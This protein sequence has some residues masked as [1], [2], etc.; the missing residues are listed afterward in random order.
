MKA[1][2]RILQDVQRALKLKHRREA[3]R[4]SGQLDGPVPALGTGSLTMNR[5]S[6]PLRS[7][8][9][10]MSTSP[11]PVPTTTTDVT[12]PSSSSAPLAPSSTTT[13][14]APTA[15]AISTLTAPSTADIDFSPSTG[16]SVVRVR[17]DPHRRLH[18]IP[19]S[20]DGGETLDWSGSG[21]VNGYGSEDEKSE[22]AE[23][24]EKR[25]SLSVSRRGK[26]KEKDKERELLPSAEDLKRLEGLYPSFLG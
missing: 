15:S 16:P 2:P 3:R 4:K 7:S 25:W 18:P 6:S 9:F 13:P 22:K 26:E 20:N 14:S 17:V 12:Q 10:P 11:T 21:S 5:P 23:K 19:L 1:D 24:S 8:V